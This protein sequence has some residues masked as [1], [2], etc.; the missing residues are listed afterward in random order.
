MRRKHKYRVDFFASQTQKASAV[1]S[2]CE[3]IVFTSMER[4]LWN[5]QTGARF[6]CARHC[7]HELKPS[8]KRTKFVRVFLTNISSILMPFCAALSSRLSCQEIEHKFFVFQK[9][10]LFTAQ[11]QPEMN[12]HQRSHGQL[13]NCPL[14]THL[15]LSPKIDRA[16]GVRASRQK[17]TADF[18]CRL[19]VGA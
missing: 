13:L 12:N 5:R 16:S 19:F 4:Y 7:R 14:P 9:R 17:T 2:I 10:K 3:A 1:R 8:Q 18:C 6:W 11:T 15:E